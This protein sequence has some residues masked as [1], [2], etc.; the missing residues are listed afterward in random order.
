[1]TL[2]RQSTY[3]SPYHHPDAVKRRAKQIAHFVAGIKEFVPGKLWLRAAKVS[4]Q[5]SPTVQGRIYYTDGNLKKSAYPI[6]A[7]NPEEAVPYTFPTDYTVAHAPLT[8]EA[9]SDVDPLSSLHNSYIE[10]LLRIKK[11][12]RTCSEQRIA[13]LI[14]VPQVDNQQPDNPQMSTQ[15]IIAETNHVLQSILEHEG[16]LSDDEDVDEL[17]G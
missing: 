11:M 14:I 5:S 10:D 6:K 2:V 3:I 15:E 1:M 12:A 7:K 16:L 13:P 9:S 17:Y 4:W 8:C